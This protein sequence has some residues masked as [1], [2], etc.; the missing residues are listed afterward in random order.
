MPVPHTDTG[1]PPS[2]ICPAPD[3]RIGENGSV[4]GTSVTPDKLEC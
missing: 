4:P 1:P 3:Q 2:L